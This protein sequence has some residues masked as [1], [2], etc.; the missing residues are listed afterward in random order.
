MFVSL[1]KT[2]KLAGDYILLL[3][4]PSLLFFLL[5]I[6]PVADPIIFTDNPLYT[7]TR[8]NDKVLENDNLTVTKP[9]LKR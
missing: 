5:S 8:Y 4:I 7:D 6:L 9:S 1:C 3:H 2:Y